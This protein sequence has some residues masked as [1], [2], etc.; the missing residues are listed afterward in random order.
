MTGAGLVHCPNLA[1]TAVSEQEMTMPDAPTDL[2]RIAE[3]LGLDDSADTDAILTAIKSTATPD[4]ARFVP[5]EAVTDLLKQRNSVA[6]DNAQRV[7]EVEV[8]KA[9]NAG[10]LTPAMRDWSVALCT[11]DPDS[12]AS[13]V[14]SATPAYAHLHRGSGLDNKSLPEPGRAAPGDAAAICSQLGLA[15]DDLK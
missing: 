2:A 3:A 13:F 4:P 14:T 15:P 7:A 12:F 1:L 11:Q 10:Y 9:M 5:I 6:S 8:E